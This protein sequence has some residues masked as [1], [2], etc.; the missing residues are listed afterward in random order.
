MDSC[1]ALSLTC[2]LYRDVEMRSLRRKLAAA[3]SLNYR[4]RKK[5][6]L[7]A[8]RCANQLE[9]ERCARFILHEVLLSSFRRMDSLEAAARTASESPLP[10]T[11]PHEPGYIHPQSE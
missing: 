8:E 2:L 9:V 3:H 1:A 7:E 11:P 6:Q 4:L 10:A 5:A